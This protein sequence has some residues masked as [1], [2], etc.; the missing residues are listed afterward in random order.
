MVN[1]NIEGNINTAIKRLSKIKKEAIEDNNPK[2][3]NVKKIFTETL[4]GHSFLSTKLSLTS[5]K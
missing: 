4:A 5:L 2:E 1:N 3:M